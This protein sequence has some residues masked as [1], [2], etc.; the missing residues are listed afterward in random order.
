MTMMPTSTL[1]LTHRGRCSASS[2]RCT[3]YTALDHLHRITL[4]GTPTQ[5]CAVCQH[6]WIVHVI[7]DV[8]AFPDFLHH[9]LRGGTG[10]GRCAGFWNSSIP[11]D[12]ASQCVCGAE[13]GHHL[14]WTS[15]PSES[16]LQSHTAHS[17]V[18]LP[19]QAHAPPSTPHAFSQPSAPAYPPFNYPQPPHMSY[20]LLPNRF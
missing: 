19:G 18:Y 2:C 9:W 6:P 11:W 5:A 1:P 12:V 16:A 17:A 13:W 7:A 8:R 14:P 15:L 4:P 3:N 20:P 10:D